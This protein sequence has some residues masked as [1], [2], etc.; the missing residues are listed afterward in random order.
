MTLIE[1]LIV[2]ALIALMMA[3]LV[4]GSGMLTSSRQH[5]AASAVVSLLR[6]A[7]TRAN[8]SGH[9]VRIVFDLDQDKL[10]LEEST[11]RMLRDTQSEDDKAA[12]AK[13]ATD[14]EAEAQKE[15]ERIL[16]GPSAPRPEF[17]PAPPLGTEGRELGS[18]VEFRQVQT[19]H[20]DAPISEGRAYLYVWPGGET[21]RASVQIRR[22]GSTEEEQTLTVS[23]SALTGRARIERGRVDLPETKNDDGEFSEREEE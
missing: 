13:A 3:T 6:L 9:S 11:S 14:A 22:Q 4:F 10:F 7:I 20:D 5:A 1:V 17:R 18:G 21:E 16:Q 23:I 2:V 19:Q 15:A 12:G 8:S